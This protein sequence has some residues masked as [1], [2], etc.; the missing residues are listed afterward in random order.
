MKKNMTFQ[1][2]K[3]DVFIYYGFGFSL[4]LLN[5]LE[6]TFFK[7]ELVRGLAIGLLIIATYMTTVFL[8]KRKDESFIENLEVG[9]QDERIMTESKSDDA[10]LFKVML[11]L[12]TL[13]VTISIFKDFSFKL[14]GGILLWCNVIGF[15]AMKL[16]RTFRK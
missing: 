11:G 12:L 3:R 10:F 4:L 7:Y 1:D 16:K 5:L 6:F 13:M 8:L 14:G 15:V 2:Y 9:Y